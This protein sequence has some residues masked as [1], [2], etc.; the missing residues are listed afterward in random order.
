MRTTIA[1]LAA[2][3]ALSPGAAPAQTIPPA[4]QTETRSPLLG[5]VPDETITDTT[6]P[7]SLADALARGLAHNLGVV[8]SREA[9]AEAQ[10]V[11]LR[12]LSALL[13]QVDG[14]LSATRQKVNL[15]A[16]GFTGFGGIEIDPLVGPFNVVDARV[17]VS[18][19]VIDLRAL[20]DEK[21]D[22][23]RLT[24]AEFAEADARDFVVLVCADLY[25]HAVASG[26]RV[27][28]VR[29]ELATAEALERLAQ[30][31]KTAG[32]AAGIEVLRAQV[33]V[34]SRREQLIAAEN[35]REKAKL[36]LA[37]AIG[38]PLAQAFTLTDEVP[39]APIE[40]MPVDAAIDLAFESRADLAQQRA[41]LGAAQAAS[42]AA[43]GEGLPSLY[44]TGDYGAIGQT[45]AS[46]LGTFSVAASVRVPLFH[47]GEVR[48]K[49]QEADSRV[50]EAQAR[51]ADLKGK[52]EY[53]VRGALLDLQSAS[54]QLEAVRAARTL[55]E[56]QLTQAT[57]RFSAG[58]AS[59]L[60]VVEGQ[61][62]V[63]TATDRYID[64]LYIYNTAKAAFA[65]SLGLSEERAQELAGEGRP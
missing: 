55:A 48:A 42:R 28:A 26:T 52:I 1:V 21:A 23:A 37:R 6:L 63:A 15:A 11:R 36:Q 33:E 38:L 8:T 10:A 16:F 19:A 47:G 31:R 57:D 40:P 41:L 35:G 20:N 34:Q 62:A 43:T 4:L 30:D 65:R 54:Q 60:E 46:A 17:S 24:A 29:A 56:A 45:P 18:Q 25:L 7:L 58:V 27:A 5:S 64:T 59:N 2:L 14:R 50:R 61:Q 9:R 32:L 12:S 13:P 53:E 49:R 22:R 44:V 51:L 3:V 39:Y